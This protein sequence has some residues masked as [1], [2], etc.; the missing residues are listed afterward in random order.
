MKNTIILIAILVASSLRLFAGNYEETMGKNIAQLYQTQNREELVNLGNTF[1]RIA[2]KESSKWLPYYYASYANLSVLFFNQNLNA[3]E[4]N[5][6][7]DK[8]QQEL[9]Q[10]LK[11]TER[12]SEIFV[13]Q[14]FIYQMR[15][16]DP[17]TG[18]KYSTLSNEA[19]S[20]AKTLNPE[21]PRYYYLKGTNLF[22]TPTDFGGGKE[23][24][25]PLFEKASELFRQDN[26][27]NALMPAWGNQHNS[28]MLQQCQ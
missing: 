1:N 7:L 11:I 10:A 20:K 26:H 28:M 16:T 15:I 2:Q 21:N 23:A 4:K 22:Y 14:A 8:A 5:T 24:A 9:D 27:E 6:I 12:E 18:Y 3:E 19:L 17:S 25:K 13:L